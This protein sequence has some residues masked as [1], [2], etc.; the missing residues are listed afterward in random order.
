MRKLSL[1]VLTVICA[2][3]LAFGI[4]LMSNAYTAKA[5]TVGITPTLSETKVLIST[6]QDKML[7]ATA[8]KNYGDVYEI[9]YTFTGDVQPTLHATDTYYTSITGGSDT[10]TPS[11]IFGENWASDG[12]GMIIWEI[13]FS[14]GTAYEYKA[15]ALVGDRNGNNQ[16]VVP[17]HEVRI[18][19][20]TATSKTFYSVTVSSNDANYGS[21]DKTDVLV[22]GGSAVSVSN[23]VITV[24]GIAITAT[25][26]DENCRFYDFG[27]A[28]QTV[29]ANTD[30]TANFTR[31]AHRETYKVGLAKCE[32]GTSYTDC[33]YIDFGEYVDGGKVTVEFSGKYKPNVQFFAEGVT[34]Q[35]KTAPKAGIMF[36]DDAIGSDYRIWPNTVVDSGAIVANNVELKKIAYNNLTDGKNYVLEITCVKGETVYEITVKL[37]EKSGETLTDVASYT[38]TRAALPDNAGTHI[39]VYGSRITGL[40][41]LNITVE[42]NEVV[43]C[44]AAYK[45]SLGGC[46]GGTS[47]TDCSYIDFGEYVDG[48][49]VTIECSGKYK[50]QVQ[51]FAEGVTKQMKTNTKAGIMFSDDAVGVDYRIYPNTVVDSGAIVSG[52]ANLTSMAYSNLADGKYVLE[53]TCVKISTSYQIEVKL[54]VKDATTGE[55]TEVSAYTSALSASDLPANTGTHIVV[56]GSRIGALNNLNIT[57]ESKKKS[58]LNP[59]QNSLNSL[60]KYNDNQEYLIYAYHSPVPAN[61]TSNGVDQRTVEGYKQHLDGGFNVL[62]IQANDPYYGSFATSQLKKNL[63]NARLSGYDKVIITDMRLH[64]LSSR[65]EPFIGD[66]KDYATFEDFVSQVELWTDEYRYYRGGMVVGVQLVDEPAYN[67]LPQLGQVYKAIKTVWPEC[68]IQ[69]NLLPLDNTAASGRYVPDGFTG[70][71]DQAYEQYLT[72]FCEYTGATNITMDSYPIRGAQSNGYYFITDTHMRCLQIMQK[73]AKVYGCDI[74]AVANACETR[75]SLGNVKLKLPDQDEMFWQV[76]VYMGYGS[77]SFSYYTYCIK[78]GDEQTEGSCFVGRDGDTTDM[79]TYMTEIHREMQT[80]APVIMNFDYNTYGYYYNEGT[81]TCGTVYLTHAYGET[82]SKNFT[83]LQDVT[84]DNNDVAFVTEL[85]DSENNQY[86]YML[87]NPQHPSNSVK[88]NIDLHTVMSFDTSYTKLE[89][90]KEGEMTI[91]DLVDGKATFDLEA[92]HAVFV[93]PT[94]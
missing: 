72:A 34:K 20:E 47:Y 4:G 53:I 51:F 12:V 77:K 80:F 65:T 17:A 22:P 79:Y 18:T 14:A 78:P 55:L 68:F 76:N 48:G 29:T 6:A 94:R 73:V 87:M 5:D 23:N 57:V 46:A 26:A 13:P 21:V 58:S 28:P 84:V 30:I 40:N 69:A 92:G 38:G 56:Y 49:K 35:M 70:T 37:S 7:L 67:V 9:G 81:V 8:I 15:Y 16:L 2:L 45:V 88:C 74:G 86:M 39:V 32:G 83:A 52:I 62:L 24:G 43:P 93:I 36:S 10:L 71:A 50:P 63:D 25:A 64:S 61:E 75:D 42:G 82:N 41:N 44:N 89:V 85:I 54:F 66:G 60:Q 91:V 19:P 1:T 59:S 27:G 33:S 3:C 31:F 11:D 90:W